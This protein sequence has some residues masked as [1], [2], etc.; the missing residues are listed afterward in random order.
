MLGY[1]TYELVHYL[2]HGT[3]FPQRFNH[4]GWVRRRYL[5]HRVHHFVNAQRNFGFTLL[6]WDDLFGTLD[7]ND[8]SVVRVSSRGGARETTRYAPAG[9]PSLELAPRR[10]VREP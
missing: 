3:A 2:F 8:T 4:L 6:I 1:C 7:L 9:L 10:L 5:A